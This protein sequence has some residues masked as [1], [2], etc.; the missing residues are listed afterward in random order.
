MATPPLPR[1]ILFEIRRFGSYM[2][3]AAICG[4][5]GVEAIMVGPANVPLSTLKMNA[6][7]KLAYVL[8]KQRQA[9]RR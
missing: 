9:K 6:A 1:E 2:R 5:T 7:R 3:V 4:D 8:E